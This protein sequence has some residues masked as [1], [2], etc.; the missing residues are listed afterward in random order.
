MSCARLER[1]VAALAGAAAGG[2]RVL[3]ADVRARARH[4]RLNDHRWFAL[5]LRYV[6]VRCNK[7]NSKLF[8]VEFTTVYRL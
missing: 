3:G 6:Q 2:T 5:R 7:K 8:E 4:A 1:E